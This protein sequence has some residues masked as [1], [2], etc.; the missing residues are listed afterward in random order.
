VLGGGEQ[1]VRGYMAVV[2]GN[3]C[4]LADKRLI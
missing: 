1:G 4:E 2:G 3:G